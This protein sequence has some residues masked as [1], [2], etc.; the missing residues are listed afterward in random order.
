MIARIRARVFKPDLLIWHPSAGIRMMEGR[1][2]RKIRK[3]LNDTHADFSLS[4]PA[5][6]FIREAKEYV[7]EFVGFVPF[8]EVLK[9]N[10]PPKSLPP[11]VQLRREHRYKFS[12][13][14]RRSLSKKISEASDRDKENLREKIF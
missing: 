14:L 5:Q 9:Y 1:Q 4:K 11:Y 6:N 2:S 13:M 12:K 3:Y 8:S 10:K 7:K